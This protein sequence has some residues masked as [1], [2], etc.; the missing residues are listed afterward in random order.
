MASTSYKSRVIIKE[1]TAEQADFAGTYNLLLAAKSIPSPASPPNT[2]ESTTMED[3][4]QTFEKGIKTADSREI[5][6]N[7]AKE[8][9]ENI[10]KLGDKKVDI[11]HLYGTDGIGGVAKYAYTGTDRKSVV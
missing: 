4:Q 9:L 1:H 6:G 11:I 8:Y 7:L 5:T 10:E 3:P 2:V